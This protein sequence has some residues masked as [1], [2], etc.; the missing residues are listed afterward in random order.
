VHQKSLFWA[1][2]KCSVSQCKVL[3]PH[4]KAQLFFTFG[5]TTLLVMHMLVYRTMGGA[6]NNLTSQI[7]ITL[8]FETLEQKI[9][10]IFLLK[11]PVA[12]ALRELLQKQTIDFFSTTKT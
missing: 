2:S 4:S 5:S 7:M 6:H 10:H 11:F 3:N 8:V 1:R 9:S 12:Y